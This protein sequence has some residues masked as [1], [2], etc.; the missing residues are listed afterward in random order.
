MKKLLL[1]ST[2][3]LLC[4]CGRSDLFPSKEESKTQV[5]RIRAYISSPILQVIVDTPEYEPFVFYIPTGSNVKV[6]DIVYWD[7]EKNGI[8]FETPT[9]AEQQIEKP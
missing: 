7:H 1:I 2:I 6:G 9:N 3:A 8:I 5:I 4:S